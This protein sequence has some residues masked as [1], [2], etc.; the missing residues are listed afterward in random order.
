MMVTIKKVK[1]MVKVISSGEMARPFKETSTKIILKGTAS[2]Y[3]MMDERLRVSGKTIKCMVGAHSGGQMVVRIMESTRKI[4][5]M[6][7]VS[8]VGLTE[9]DILASGRMAN[10]TVRVSI[11]ARKENQL[12]ASGTGGKG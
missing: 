5:S 8:L 10:S 2:I 3:G 7:L 4:R 9:E 6:G 11:L 12:L 1:S